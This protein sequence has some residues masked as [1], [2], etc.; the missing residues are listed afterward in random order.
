MPSYIAGSLLASFT[1]K[2]SILSSRSWI[3]PVLSENLPHLP[4]TCSHYSHDGLG[5]FLWDLFKSD[6]LFLTFLNSFLY[7]NPYSEFFG[8]PSYIPSL[9][10]SDS[11]Y[12]AIIMTHLVLYIDEIEQSFCEWD[13]ELKCST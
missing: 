13:Q 3:L 4:G 2:L 8:F 11:L 5:T 10:F 1:F 9:L 6:F 12:P 7:L